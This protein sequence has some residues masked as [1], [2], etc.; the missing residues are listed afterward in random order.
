MP[1]A[2]NRNLEEKGKADFYEIQV[3]GQLNNR[4]SEWLEGL[5]LQLLE[6]GEMLLYGPIIDQAALM[7]VLNK[8]CCLNLTILAVNKVKVT[9][10]WRQNERE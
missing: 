5:G 3:K 7:G 8:L 1:E 4:W 2:N 10:N 9:D 6:N